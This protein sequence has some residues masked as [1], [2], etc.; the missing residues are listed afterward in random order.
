MQGDVPTAIVDLPEETWDE[1]EDD[2]DAL[3]SFIVSLPTIVP[4]VLDDIE[5]GGEVVVSI[6]TE[7]IQNP[8]GALTVF[9]DDVETVFDNVLGDIETVA[10]EVLTGIE[11]LFGDCP[12]A[13][14]TPTNTAQAN[15]ISACNN[16]LASPTAPPAATSTPAAATISTLA[17]ETSYLAATTSSLAAETST[18]AAAIGTLS[19]TGGTLPTTTSPSST[20]P[21]GTGGSDAENG[22]GAIG[23]KG[24]AAW[25]LLAALVGAVVF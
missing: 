24:P 9:V 15:L 19:T 22:A 17:A 8:G 7:L 23:Q 13:T 21:S 6:I 18:L 16:V 5:Q 10:G 25:G 1:I 4:A 20:A 3:T 14:A 2:F 11:C 12:A